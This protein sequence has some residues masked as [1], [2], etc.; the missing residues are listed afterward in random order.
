MWVGRMEGVR[1]GGVGSEWVGRVGSVRVG[2]L[3]SV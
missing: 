1:V 3:E 2:R